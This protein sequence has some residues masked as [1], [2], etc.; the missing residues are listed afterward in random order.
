MEKKLNHLKEKLVYAVEGQLSN[1]DAADTKELGEVIDMIKDL[2]EA[3]YYCTI[4]K[5]MEEA[6]KEKEKGGQRPEVY[7]YTEKYLPM[8]PYMPQRGGMSPYYRDMDRPMGRMYYDDGGMLYYNGNGQG[9]NGS[10]GG[11]NSGNQDGG[12]RSYY[13]RY[14]MDMME[15]AEKMMM[16]RQKDER[17]GRSPE[18]RRS[19]MEGKE[20]KKD[21][22]HQMQEL[23]KYMQE[24]ATD[25][26]E[27]IED[28]SPEEK[29]LLHQKI[30]ELANK[31]K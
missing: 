2:E 9:G 20:M 16:Q 29:Q 27:M 24:L 11:S 22:V 17:E 26:T 15:P 1:I 31:I 5:S 18:R 28:A 23:N 14:R 3:V 12:T 4:T 10:S 13:D 21:R 25:M 8:E 6:S 30:A 19:Y 7:Y